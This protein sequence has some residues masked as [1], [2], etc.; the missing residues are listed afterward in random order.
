MKVNLE[1][2]PID[3][4]PDYYIT[5]EGTVLTSRCSNKYHNDGRLRILKPKLHKRGYVYV[6]IYAG[7]TGDSIRVWKRV[8]RLVYET[9]IGPIPAN[10]EIDHCN[11]IKSDN[12]VS[13]LQSVSRRENMKRMWRR[14]KDLQYA[15]SI[16]NELNKSFD[17]FLDKFITAN[18][19]N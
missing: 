13:N 14:K 7:D 9:F 6:G 12:R 5:T 17:D 1:M 18:E 8:H 10:E 15:N 19:S 2:K 16:E 3:G 4:F 11:G